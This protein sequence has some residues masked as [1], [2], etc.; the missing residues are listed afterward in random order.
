MKK[1]IALVIAFSLT[2]L[3]AADALQTKEQVK[4]EK[5]SE[6]K[7]KKAKTKKAKKA[8]SVNKAQ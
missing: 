3:F 4:T 6:Q 8:K 7:V 2:S 1:I 5:K